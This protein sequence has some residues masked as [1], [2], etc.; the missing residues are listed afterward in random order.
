MH[1]LMISDVYF[2]RINGVS[3]SIETF[4]EEL[5]RAGH[6]VTLI[7]PRYGE[8]PDEAD[9]IRIPSRGLFFDREDRMMKAGAIRRLLPRLREADIDCVHVQTPFVAHYLGVWLARRLG[10]PVVESYHT[11]FEE[12]LYNYIGWIPRPL[13][14]AAARH[15]SRTQCAQVQQVISPSRP[16]RDALEGYGIRQPI[17]ILPTGLREDRF[18]SGDRKGFRQRHG[19]PAGAPVCLNV[20]RVAFEKNLDFLLEMFV[21][22]RERLPDAVLVIA[23]EGPA[24]RHL[25]RRARELGLAE[26]VH[27]IGYLDRAH[28]LLDC[29]A[30]AD[31]F[32]F[33][34]RTETQGL[35][36]LEAMA[37]GLPV[38]STAVMG[39]RDILGARRGALVPE[40]EVS[41][42]AE[43]VVWLLSDRGLH[44]RL[45]RE[46]R[47][48]AREWSATA[49]AARMTGV[50]EELVD[51]EPVEDRK[52]ATE[53]A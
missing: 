38:V 25:H 49:M 34:S 40:E 13:L 53:E 15:L 21:S 48:Y 26:A 10:V 46:A 5:I 36:L 37:M 50:Y 44:D 14:Q 4:R 30:A 31:A 3:T 42:F 19:I 28:E 8:E 11:Y 47:S 35:V 18:G 6:R 29:Y 7:A 33:A 41:G 1:I 45:A 43:Q 17:E 16:M 12:Y 51:A 2:P 23:G 32:V 52:T 27:F 9:V 22:V 24:E 39:T 20:G